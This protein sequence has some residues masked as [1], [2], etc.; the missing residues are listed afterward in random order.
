MFKDSHVSARS[1]LLW[2]HVESLFS[3]PDGPCLQ[4]PLPQLPPP[5]TF[6]S[7]PSS[8]SA[9]A[10]KN[11]ERSHLEMFQQSQEG[12]LAQEMLPIMD[13]PLPVSPHPP[14]FFSS[15]W[16]EAFWCYLHKGNDIRVTFLSHYTKG[17]LSYSF[18]DCDI[19]MRALLNCL[20]TF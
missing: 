13:Q 4:A 1:R 20:T 8:G 18:E 14:P 6:Q 12:K 2:A 3:S 16:V 10:A 7:I 9:P 5:P 19:P 15:F 11:A 17:R